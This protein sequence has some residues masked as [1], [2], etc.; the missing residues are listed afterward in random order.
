[1]IV[2]EKMA[3]DG[4]AKWLLS[5]VYFVSWAFVGYYYTCENQLFVCSALLEMLKLML[6]LMCSLRSALVEGSVGSR[7]GAGGGQCPRNSESGPPCGPP[8]WG[9]CINNKMTYNTPPPPPV[10]HSRPPTPPSDITIAPAR[11]P[12]PG[13]PLKL[14]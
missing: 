6:M 13:P 8:E 11:W 9:V 3:S 5:C 12:H 4:V 7:G 14:V 2:V 10:G 1:M